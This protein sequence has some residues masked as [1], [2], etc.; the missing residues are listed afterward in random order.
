[1]CLVG[2]DP[3][4]TEYGS[5]GESNVCLCDEIFLMS[6]ERKTLKMLR[7]HDAWPSFMDGQFPFY[8]LDLYIQTLKDIQPIDR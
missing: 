5:R 7:H 1:M 8:K 3:I 4:N 6:D 2:N